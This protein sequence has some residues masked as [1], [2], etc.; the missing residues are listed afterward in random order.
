MNCP[1]WKYR[2]HPALGVFQSTFVLTDAA[3]AELEADWN[4]DPTTTG[5]LISPQM[6]YANGMPHAVPVADASGEPLP[7]DI[8]VTTTGDVKNA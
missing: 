4:D 2:K 5:F 8:A 3:E 6:Q 1:K 7:A